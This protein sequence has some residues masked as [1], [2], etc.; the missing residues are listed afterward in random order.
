MSP[1]Q[2][3]NIVLLL[4]AGLSNLTMIVEPRPRMF[5]RQLQDTNADLISF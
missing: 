5:G 4:F 2:V 3:L 1:L